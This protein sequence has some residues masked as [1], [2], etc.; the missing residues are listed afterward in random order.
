[1]L[2]QSSR[3]RDSLCSQLVARTLVR[4]DVSEV[5]VATIFKVKRLFMLPTSS[6]DTP[7]DGR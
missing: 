4:I 7:H 6:E 5:H 3:Q 2:P 1:M